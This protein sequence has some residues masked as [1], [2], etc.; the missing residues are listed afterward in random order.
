MPVLTND[1]FSLIKVINVLMNTMF[2]PD[3]YGFIHEYNVNMLNISLSPVLIFVNFM[4][5]FNKSGRWKNQMS[6]IKTN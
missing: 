1:Q 6:H 5:G 3:I 4:I 2:Q